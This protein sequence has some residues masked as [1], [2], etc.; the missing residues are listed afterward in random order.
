MKKKLIRVAAPKVLLHVPITLLTAVSFMT[1][2]ELG[3]TTSEIS[4]PRGQVICAR[5]ETN[6]QN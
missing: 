2:S 1:L 5:S 6:Q 3:S 4:K